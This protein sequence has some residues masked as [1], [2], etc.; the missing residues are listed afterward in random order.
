MKTGYPGGTRLPVDPLRR[1]V[2]RDAEAARG[3][4]QLA[5]RTRLHGRSL[6]R[7]LRDDRHHVSEAYADR[8]CCATNRHISSLYPE[9]YE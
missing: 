6:A 7:L 5:R 4:Y 1:V 9:L 2:Q 8:Y 3:V